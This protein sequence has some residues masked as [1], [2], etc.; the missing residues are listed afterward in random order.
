MESYLKMQIH[1]CNPETL[2][3][4]ETVNDHRS[5]VALSALHSTQ[6]H[7]CEHWKT[8]GRG[9]TKSFFFFL[10]FGLDPNWHKAG[11]MN[12]FVS[13]IKVI[14]QGGWY[15]VSICKV[16][17]ASVH[18]VVWSPAFP[19]W[20]AL[21]QGSSSM[22][23]DWVL[24]SPMRSRLHPGHLQESRRN[25]VKVHRLKHTKTVLLLVFFFLW[26]CFPGKSMSTF[27]LPH[28]V[29]GSYLPPPSTSVA[30]AFR[31]SAFLP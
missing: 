21:F 3:K 5:V 20:Q 31:F 15:S 30:F 8:G 27:T 6:K 1:Q 16:L 11:E 9:K 26:N 28:A 7:T 23:H 19:G 14:N 17:G 4:L 29:P 12:I 18:P 13:I 10:L 25:S 22:R 24:G 2:D